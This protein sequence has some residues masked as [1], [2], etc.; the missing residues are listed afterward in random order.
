M[1]RRNGDL[2]WASTHAS[3]EATGAESV[4]LSPCSLRDRLDDFAF[5]LVRDAQPRVAKPTRAAE[6]TPSIDLYGSG[7]P[8]MRRLR[9]RFDAADTA[10][11]SRLQ[12]S[13]LI[14]RL[15]SFVV[16]PLSLRFLYRLAICCGRRS[17]DQQYKHKRTE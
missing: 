7:A 16:R 9:R 14:R 13:H 11:G 15:C 5:G 4:R 2:G 12:R 17:L 8:A 3:I 1:R 6:P 10:P